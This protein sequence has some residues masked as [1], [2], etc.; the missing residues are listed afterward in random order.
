M[1]TG[2]FKG[3][4]R[5]VSLLGLGCMRFPVIGGE[6]SKIDYEKAQ[7]IVDYS[8]EKGIN[9]LD[10]AHGYHGGESQVFLGEA[11]KKYPRESYHLATK[12]PMWGVNKSEDLSEIFALQQKRLQTD[13]FDFYLLHA[14]D[15]E[16]YEKVLKFKAYDFV[17]KLKDEGKVKNIGFSFHDSPEVLEKIASSHKWDF[18]QLQINYVDWEAQRAREQYEILQKYDILVIIMEPVRGGALANPGPRA[19]KLLKQARPDKSIASW[20]LR[21]AASRPGVLTVLSGMSNMDQLE[22]NIET[23]LNF[24]PLTPA[25]YDLLN[26]VAKAFKHKDLIPCTA[27]RYCM[28]DCPNGIDIP[29]V[30][31]IYNRF[32][33]DGDEKAFINDYMTIA[34]SE[35]AQNCI[36][37]HNCKPYCP[38]FIEIPEKLKHISEFSEKLL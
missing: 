16:K 3:L 32:V 2:A 9:Y 15:A 23:L 27:C 35:R 20:A 8:L 5:P 29:G 19:E 13:Y 34:E 38:Q 11:L 22:D 26:E 12:M 10:T 18:A 24:E 14:L 33:N 17:S 28:Q 36:E 4:E 25:D 31:T 7:E 30:F 6:D 37:C 21:Y 1:V